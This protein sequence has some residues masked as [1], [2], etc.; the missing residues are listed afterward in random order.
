[1]IQGGNLRRLFSDGWN[2]GKQNQAKQNDSAN[3][4]SFDAESEKQLK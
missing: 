3:K 1:M 4:D 2:Q